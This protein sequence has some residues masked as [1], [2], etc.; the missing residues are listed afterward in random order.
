MNL[1]LFPLG[2][3][4]LVASLAALAAG[5]LVVLRP[6]R[7][8]LAG[9]DPQFP[10]GPVD[11]PWGDHRFLGADRLLQCRAAA[12]VANE[13]ARSADRLCREPRR[14]PGRVHAAG[15]S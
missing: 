1:D 5:I 14:A 9:S 13:A 2:W 7:A 12:E 11:P 3:V 6:R 15:L 4:H 8:A 10:S